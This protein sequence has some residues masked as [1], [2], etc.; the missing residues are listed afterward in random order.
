MKKA[1]L[2]SLIS[3]IALLIS[4]M[5]GSLIVQAAPAAATIPVN[6]VVDTEHARAAISPYIYG[7]NQ[8]IAG[9]S[10]WTVRRFGGNRTTGFNW[11][12]NASNAGSDYIHSSDAFVCTWVG[13]TDCTTPGSALSAYHDKSIQTG[14]TDI[15]TL[16]MAGY[17]AKDKNGTVAASEVA[18]SPRWDPV[19][20]AKG[21]AFANP[22]SLTDN[23]VYMDEEVNYLVQKYGSASTANGVKIYALDNEPALWSSTHPRIHPTQPGAAELITRS[24]ALS[25]AVKAVDPAAMIFGPAA[26]GFYEMYAFQ[27]APDW[28]SLKGNYAWYVDYYLAQM[29]AASDAS[30]KRLLDAFDLHWYPE[31]QGGGQRIVF[32]GAGTVDTQKA[33]VQA[34]RSLWDPTYLETSWIADSFPSFLPL[35]PR[36]QQSI[37]TYY[38]GTKLAITE[39]SYGGEADISGG[40]ATADVLGVFGKYGVYAGTFWQL[41]TAS[42]YVAAA[43]N[44]YRNYNGSNGKFGDTKID[45]SNSNIVDSSMYASI[46]GT[47]TSK[48]D[49]VVMNKNFDSD[50]TGSFTI[51]SP[52]N[53]TS[54]Q[55]WGFDS[56]SST[57]T[58]RTAISSITGNTFT[59]TIPARTAYHIVLNAGT[60]SATNTPRPA[61]ATATATR[62]ATASMTPCYGCGFKLQYQ[63]GDTSATPNQLTPHFTIFNNSSAAVPLS[64]FKIRYWYTNE[65][66]KAQ[67]YACDF[68]VV[69]CANT[70]GTFVKMSSP[71]TGADNYIEVSFTAA[72]GSIAVGGN[73]GGIQT[74]INKSDFS[75]YTQTGDYSFDATKTA[76]ADWDHVTLYRNGGLV[77]GVEPGMGP[78]S[79]PGISST[80]TRTLAPSL[81]PTLGISPTRTLTPTATAI[82]STSTPTRTVTAGVTSTPTRTLTPAISPTLTRTPTIGAATSTATRTL[83]P[84]AVT[85]TP[86]RTP[87]SGASPTP[88]VGACSPVSS[89]ITAPFTFDG[90]GTLCWQSSSLGTYLNSWNTSSVTINGVNVTNLYLA[91]GSYPAK[92]SGFWYVSYTSTVAWGHFE[93]K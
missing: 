19:I 85:V 18:P 15:I 39:F 27:D 77:W 28:P 76:Y 41:E 64:E 67:T 31:A 40:L 89:T 26:Y 52:V 69:G 66:N 16:Q 25:K 91:A 7:S 34:P 21:S 23:A 73:S 48:V 61:T 30:G 13:V 83:T 53:Y 88:G 62:T 4:N 54:G 58:Q 82:V 1:K 47:D 81:T 87:T 59:Y 32:N 38:P 17:V 43:Y 68:A 86:T 35:L 36:V 92:I 75:N 42:P 51:Y 44:L 29:K 49:I 3:L 33:R 79:T 24:V 70:V 5:S 93:S 60:T 8:D 9:V 37:N 78:T 6:F 14:A 65:G 20:F 55:V 2:F 45:T 11:E 46:T 71:Q 72:A 84:P 22:P 63:A 90:A 50:I 74:R 56:A 10:N 80:P 57:I 12:N